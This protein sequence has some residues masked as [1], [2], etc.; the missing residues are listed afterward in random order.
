MRKSKMSLK[1]TPLLTIMTVALVCGVAV[2]ARVQAKGRAL[3]V[4]SELDER[5]VKELRPLYKALENVTWSL[6]SKIPLLNKIY[7]EKKLLTGKEASVEGSQEYLVKMLQDSKIET[8]DLILGVH[9]L[10]DKIAFRDGIIEATKW[11]EGIK[12]KLQM[13]GVDQKVL[14]KLGLLYNLSC[15][16]VS[17]NV[18]FLNLGFQVVVG[19]RSVN[20][21]AELE[22]PWVLEML[23]LG[24][25]VEDA[26]YQPNSEDWLRLADGP[27]GWLGRKQNSFLQETDSYKVI[28]GNLD[29][30][31]RNQK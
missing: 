16:G 24:Y 12:I 22:Y 23:A 5:G 18:P 30:T 6:P 7:F 25:T 9:G 10:P 31:I 8:L 13:Q 21:N 27:I 19:S 28:S 3:L 11:V 17:H 15:Y 20:A 2:P 14:N 29:Y 1:L 26:F 4:V